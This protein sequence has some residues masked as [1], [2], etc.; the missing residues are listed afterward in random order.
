MHQILCERHA[1]LHDQVLPKYLKNDADKLRARPHGLNSIAW[2]IWHLLRIE[3]ITLSRFVGNI[4]QVHTSGGWQQRMGLAYGDMGTAMASADV[5]I[6]SQTIDLAGLAGYQ[7]AVG[8]QSKQIL[9]A[10]DV[11]RA[12]QKW[13]T[14]HM[15]AVIAGEA[16]CLPAITEGVISYWGG[17]TMGRFVVD[18]T[19][20]HPNTHIG[21]M[22]VIGN[23]VGAQ[24]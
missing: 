14:A 24:V 10:F 7:A 22:Q 23:L 17:L 4:P 3:D 1:M 18:Y 5:D 12:Q 9:A 19:Q 6:L 16:V 21:E 20:V 11:S 8:A 13:D 2:N 15:R